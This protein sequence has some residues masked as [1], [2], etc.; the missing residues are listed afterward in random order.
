MRVR[1]GVLTDIHVVQDPAREAGWINRYDFAGVEER[2]R[3]A[4]TLFER[5]E[6]DCVL[7]LGDL[8]H[9]G[10]LPSLRGALAPFWPACPCSPWGETTTALAPPV[11]LPTPAAARFGCRAGGRSARSGGGRG[12]Y[13]WP[14]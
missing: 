12:R 7:L 14:A 5:S 11:A 4:R 1:L 8:A 3:R 13:G 10:D 2:C 9:D 6:V